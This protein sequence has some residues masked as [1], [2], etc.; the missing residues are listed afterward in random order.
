[1]EKAIAEHIRVVE[2]V[3]EADKSLTAYAI[4]TGSHYMLGTAKIDGEAEFGQFCKQK[5]QWSIGYRKACSNT[6]RKRH[7]LS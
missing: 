4:Y 3:N 6:S 5:R 7:E 2:S 1:V